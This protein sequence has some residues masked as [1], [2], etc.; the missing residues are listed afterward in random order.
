[1]TDDTVYMCLYDAW[2][3]QSRGNLAERDR[4]IAIALWYSTN[5]E[6]TAFPWRDGDD[7]AIARG[8]TP[9]RGD[10]EGTT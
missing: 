9:S 8:L 3:A 10:P 7:S 5:R 6:P 1:M 2:M 4:Q